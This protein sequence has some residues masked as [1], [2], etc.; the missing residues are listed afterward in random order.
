MLPQFYPQMLYLAKN[1]WKGKT[2][3]LILWSI[4]KNEERFIT[5][6]PGY[7]L[8]IKAKKSIVM[9]STIV[10]SVITHS[11]DTLSVIKLSVVVP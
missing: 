4:T 6:P 8:K 10:L 3:Q 9:L 11:N 2:L 5:M 1:A 7:V